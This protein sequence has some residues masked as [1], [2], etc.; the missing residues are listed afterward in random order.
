LISF[1]HVIE[2]I[3]GDVVI[4]DFLLVFGTLVGEPQI[5]IDDLLDL[6]AGVLDL[7]KN[8]EDLDHLPVE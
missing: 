1:E 3:D 2:G 4:D 5:D 8:C 6:D 7:E